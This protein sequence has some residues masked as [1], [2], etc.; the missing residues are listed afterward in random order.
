MNLVTIYRGKQSNTFNATEKGG[1]CFLANS[2]GI[3]ITNKMLGPYDL[4]PMLNAVLTCGK[5]L[6]AFVHVLSVQKGDPL[7]Y[8]SFVCPVNFYWTFANVT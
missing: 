8:N 1:I 3:I 5:M 6:H 7:P 4:Q 2:L